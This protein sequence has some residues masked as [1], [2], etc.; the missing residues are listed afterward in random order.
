MDIM[1]L[2]KNWGSAS[3]DKEEID[4]WTGDG[5]SC[6]KYISADSCLPLPT[7]ASRPAIPGLS[8]ASPAAEVL[9]YLS[10]FTHLLAHL[11]AKLMSS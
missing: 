10:A 7:L 11:S 3:K 8:M 6:P 4:Y 1:T 2:G 9:F 5:R